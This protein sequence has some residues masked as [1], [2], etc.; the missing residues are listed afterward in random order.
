MKTIIHF[1]VWLMGIES[2]GY[3]K[4]HIKFGCELTAILYCEVS[5]GGYIR[6]LKLDRIEERKTGE[7]YYNN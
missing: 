2:D 4:I 1:I 7:S 6:E 5:A 3:D